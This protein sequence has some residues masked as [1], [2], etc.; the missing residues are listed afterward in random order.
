M[1]RKII[2]YLPPVM[3]DYEEIQQ[4][5]GAEQTIKEKMW[6][7]L[8]KTFNE[9][10]V[11][12]QS[13]KTAALWEKTLDINSK[14]TE[15]IEVRN[16]RIISKIQ[17]KLPYTYRTLYRTLYRLLGDEKLFSMELEPE[18]FC[19]TIRVRSTSKDFVDSIFETVDEIIPAH[20]ILRV[21]F[22]SNTHEY[23]MQFPHC[24]LAHFTHSELQKLILTDYLTADKDTLS[25]YAVS[26]MEQYTKKQLKQF[27]VRKI[28]ED[29]AQR[30]KVDYMSD[31]TVDEVAEYT[32]HDVVVYHKLNYTAGSDTVA[33]M[34]KFT[35]DE[36][37]QFTVDDI[38]N[39]IL[40]GEIR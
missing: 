15:S 29:V 40:G 22:M 36:V 3:R 37:A 4:I 24:V 30:C 31:F 13:E 17:S 25:H 14:L 2:E 33:Y 11:S 6:A 21:V 7:D 19:I 38:L 5:C 26:T 1:D 8:Y 20:M 23:L 12:T 39:N 16:A 27:G 18:K 32:V 28:P 34:A 9:R 10:H 35:V